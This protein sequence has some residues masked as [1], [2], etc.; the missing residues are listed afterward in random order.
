MNAIKKLL[1]ILKQTC[2]FFTLIVILFYLISN[3]M[4]SS[5]LVLE[6]SGMFMLLL[7]SFILSLCNLI[8]GIKKLPIVIRSLTHYLIITGI[9]LFAFFYFT[10]ASASF[11]VAMV[12]AAFIA[13]I[14]AI[15][16]A[17]V[18]AVSIRMRNVKSDEEEYRPQFAKVT[19]SGKCK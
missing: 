2:I 11:G 14:Y 4:I 12:I 7:F 16:T 18:I 9:I 13:V 5:T 10:P 15:S 1:N 3:S 17:V 19:Q 8:F 6:M